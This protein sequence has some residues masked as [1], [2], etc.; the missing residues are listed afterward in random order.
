MARALEPFFS[1]KD[2]GKG[3]G[4]GLS[5]VDV[6]GIPAGWRVDAHEQ[7]GFRD[8]GGA[9]AAPVLIVSGF[10]GANAIAPDLTALSKPFRQ[11]ELV[12]SLAG[13]A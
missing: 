11:A 6:S 7:A 3:A 9:A 1:T 4:L 5:M 2:V 10:A 12:A 8:D 13:L